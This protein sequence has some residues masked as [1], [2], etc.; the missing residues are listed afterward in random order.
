M[1]NELSVVDKVVEE[2]PI[3][4]MAEKVMSVRAQAS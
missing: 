1:S 4:L 2:I 3:D